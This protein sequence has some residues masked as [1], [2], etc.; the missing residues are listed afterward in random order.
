[1]LFVSAAASVLAA[2]L[3]LP[4]PGESTAVR[5]GTVVN[6]DGSR[7]ENAVVVMVDGKITYVGPDVP[8]TP[9]PPNRTSPPNPTNRRIRTSR[10]SPRPR[11]RRNR[12]S[13][14]SPRSRPS[15]RSRR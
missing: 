14:P 13:P 2:A 7:I 6:P 3:A 4:A 15:R 11:S 8:A 5:G 10:P 1:M 9:P 12:R